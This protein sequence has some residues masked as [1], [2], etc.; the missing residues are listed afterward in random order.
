M[1]EN[2]VKIDSDLYKLLMQGDDYASMSNLEK[3]KWA[4]EL[5]DQFAMALQYLRLGNSTE[6]LKHSGQLK[7][8]EEIEFTTSDNKKIKG[9]VTADGQVIDSETG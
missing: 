1:D 7:E 9:K 6:S 4:E 2:G 5:N 3:L 8:N